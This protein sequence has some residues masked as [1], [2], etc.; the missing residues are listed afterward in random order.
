MSAP[1]PPAA[2]QSRR[3]ADFR[4]D[5]GNARRLV[6][7]HGADIH[8][9]PEWKKWII[10]RYDRWQIDTDGAVMRLAKKTVEERPG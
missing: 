7:R 3:D 5:L 9:I 10:W 4:T 6:A 2:E 1:D 8:Y